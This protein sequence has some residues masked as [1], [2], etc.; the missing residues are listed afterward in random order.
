MPPYQLEQMQIQ[1][2]GAEL[3]LASVT[4]G[5]LE[6]GGASLAPGIDVPAATAFIGNEG[7]RQALS[8]LTDEFGI[9]A[10]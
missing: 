8:Y 2:S 3:P 9:M 10:H 7:Q 1:P 4:I 6:V 5:A